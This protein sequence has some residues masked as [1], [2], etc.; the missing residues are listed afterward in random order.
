MPWL[1]QLVK[2]AAFLLWTSLVVMREAHLE[3]GSSARNYTVSW[4]GFAVESACTAS[5]AVVV[6]QK[7][8]SPSG[9]ALASCNSRTLDGVVGFLFSLPSC[10]FTPLSVVKAGGHGDAVLPFSSKSIDQA[11]AVHQ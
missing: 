11:D 2:E 5:S 8:I 9:A 1:L 3:G 10:L 4:K 6:Q 7:A